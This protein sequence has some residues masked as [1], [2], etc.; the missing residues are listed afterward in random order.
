V[1][2][3]I[4]SNAAQPIDAEKGDVFSFGI[5]VWEML[6][7]DLPWADKF[8]IQSESFSGCALFPLC[9]L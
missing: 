7:G 6:M 2:L 5:L 4:G 9:K 3:D 8:W 1:F